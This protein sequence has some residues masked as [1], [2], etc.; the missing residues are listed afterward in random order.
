MISHAQQTRLS[1]SS[2]E[3]IAD[4][5]RQRL[6][7]SP[8]RSIQRLSCQVEGRI[9]KLEGQLPSFYQNQLAQ[10]AVAGIEGVDRIVNLVEVSFQPK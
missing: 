1:A 8:Y 6:A 10:A 9:L 5:A 7:Q 4:A 2:A 3:L